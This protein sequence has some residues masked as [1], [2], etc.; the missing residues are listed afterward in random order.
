M[1]Y[2]I[3]GWN[4]IEEFDL[5]SLDP[6]DSLMRNHVEKDTNFKVGGYDSVSRGKCNGYDYLNIP[7]KHQYLALS[8]TGEACYS[9]I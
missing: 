1:K 3:I 6:A 5:S 8:T 2:E 4:L 9:R 7:I